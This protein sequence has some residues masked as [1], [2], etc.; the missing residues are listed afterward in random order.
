MNDVEVLSDLLM[1]WEELREQGLEVSAGELC[2]DCE[3]LVPA[4]EEQVRALLAMGALIEA[5]SLK[6]IE[7]DTIR[8]EAIGSTTKLSTQADYRVLCSLA[9]GGLG[10]VFVARDERLGRQV[11]LKVIRKPFDQDP[12]RMRRFVREAEITSRLEHPGIVPV[13]GI[14]RD[15]NGRLCYAMRMIGG[16]T[17]KNAIDQLHCA[18][19]DASTHRSTHLT[20]RQLIGRFVT[21]CN[22][23]AYAHSQG[24]IHRDLK[25]TNIMLGSFG[26]TL[27]VDWGLAKTLESDYSIDTSDNQTSRV[28]E[29]EFGPSNGETSTLDEYD[30][31]TI[32]GSVMGTP[33]YMSP[34]QSCGK[35]AG[36]A[37]DIYSLGSTLY[38]LIT[39]R[40]PFGG[41]NMADLSSK[42]QRGD[43][44]SPRSIQPGV[45]R[46]LESICLKAMALSPADRYATALELAEDLERWLAD[47]SV[48]AH[49]ES[50]NEEIRRWMRRHRSVTNSLAAS[51]LVTL[52]GLAGF[53]VYMSR[54]NDRLQTAYQHEG[55]A[56]AEAMASAAVANQNA[57]LAE[58]QSEL[59]LRSLQS[60]TFDIQ[61]QLRNIPAAH[62]V[63]RSLLDTALKGLTEVATKLEQRPKIDQSL[64]V[65]HRDLGDVFFEVGTDEK[66]GGS[67]AAREQF[68][69]ALDIAQKL[70]A[71]RPNDS[72][73]QREL[74]VCYEK[75]G[76]AVLRTSAVAAARGFYQQSLA[77]R[78]KMHRDNP[79]D[80]QIGRGVS[81]SLNRLGTVAMQMG[82]LEPA[83]TY[84]T[85]A[86]DLRMRYAV[87]TDRDGP[88][89]ELGVTFNHVGSVALKLGNAKEA[90]AFF[91]RSLEVFQE[92][93]KL[94]PMDFVA[95]RDPSVSFTYLGRAS[96]ALGE[97]K[98]ATDYY[99]RALDVSVSQATVDP[100]NASL[101]RDV[102]E[103]SLD[104]ASILGKLGKHDEARGHLQTAVN[105]SE[106]LVSIDLS[107][108]RAQRDLSISYDALADSLLTAKEYSDAIDLYTK[109]LAIAKKRA[110]D[111]PTDLRA[112]RG[113]ALGLTKLGDG[114]L[115]NNQIETALENFRAALAI[116]LQR[117]AENP[118]NTQLQTNLAAY[119][120]RVGVACRRLGKFDEANEHYLNALRIAERLVEEHPDNIPFHLLRITFHHSLGMLDQAHKRFN[121]AYEWYAKG[122]D[123][124]QQ[125]TIAGKL[126]GEDATWVSDFDEAIELCK[127]DELQSRES[128]A[129]PQPKETGDATGPRD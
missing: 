70:V 86:L 115:A 35:Q 72:D 6:V 15:D 83:R 97:L 126:L 103:S 108:S 94:F 104:L 49:R 18:S 55:D 74:A 29:N 85:N 21:V 9:K 20:L 110:E 117:S 100:S 98:D 62:K 56:K 43:F 90:I 101:Q 87:N 77:V 64:L 51:G 2:R 4:L 39:G 41:Q 65:A 78:E 107:D 53:L 25:P 112:T 27:V 109:S 54:T 118:T 3:H 44:L 11:A 105:L 10:E 61:R 68:Q 26:E 23:V 66:S 45:A 111:D 81:I 73:A 102:M 69:R 84:F 96:V 119:Y 88:D 63:R 71:D 82:E 13:H 125:L 80:A 47:E 58:Q 28:P 30:A 14:G 34:E 42:L 76:D 40:A 122:R 12:Q 124:A 36:P 123:I 116:H 32:Q 91:Q 57:E 17:L 50:W 114:L 113:V 106:R 128:K 59:A 129:V 67:T 79:D 95:Q 60:V 89:R 24:V 37:S 22:T 1:R 31:L 5:P 120:Q 19:V 99:R 46:P 75:L 38:A 52:V 48:T 121:E 8:A 16:E 7:S 33:A 127:N 92:R 93:S